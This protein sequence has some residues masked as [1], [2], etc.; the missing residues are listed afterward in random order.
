MLRALW[1]HELPSH[2]PDSCPLDTS[3]GNDLGLKFRHGLLVP[4]ALGVE[5]EV[6]QALQLL[7]H[8]RLGIPS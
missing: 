2:P 5:V 6:T 1:G 3:E 7:R 4:D 8:R